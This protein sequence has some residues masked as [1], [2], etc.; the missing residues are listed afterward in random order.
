[1]FP[2][3]GYPPLEDLSDNSI[4]SCTSFSSLP[5]QNTMC[6]KPIRSCNLVVKC[7]LSY[8][9]TLTFPKQK[10]LGLLPCLQGVRPCTA[11]QG[12]EGTPVLCVS[13]VATGPVW[14]TWWVLCVKVTAA[15]PN[16]LAQPPI[17]WQ[18][19]A[20]ATTALSW[21]MPRSGPSFLLHP[22]T[23]KPNHNRICAMCSTRPCLFLPDSAPSV[24][25]LGPPQPYQENLR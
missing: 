8:Y 13:S 10:S 18:A 2:A 23:R 3:H 25:P 16:F 17:H 22:L 7:G 24:S 11:P 6:W 14:P 9:A 20:T 19:W 1:M 15:T 4:S 5:D 21:P 12:A